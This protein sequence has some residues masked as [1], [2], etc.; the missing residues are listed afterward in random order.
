LF[1]F[2]HFVFRRRGKEVDDASEHVGLRQVEERVQ[3]VD[4]AVVQQQEPVGILLANFLPEKRN[5]NLLICSSL[6][7]TICVY[8]LWYVSEL[9]DFFEANIL[10]A[11]C[12]DEICLELNFVPLFLL[13]TFFCRTQININKEKPECVL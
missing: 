8:D 6:N 10:R 12:T 13:N 4:P 3:D 1:P 7:S 9:I 11:F 5:L 2:L